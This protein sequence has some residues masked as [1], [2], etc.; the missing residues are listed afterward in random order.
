MD[1]VVFDAQP[2][3]AFVF[4]EPAADQVESW[5]RRCAR[6]GC[7]VIASVNWCEVLYV[8]A[9]R[10]DEHAAARAVYLLEDSGISVIDVGRDIATRA[11]DLKA[12]HALGLGDA[13]AAA[14]AMATGSP[15]LTGDTDFL[16]LADHGLAIEWV[17][18]PRG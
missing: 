12:R 2:L 7:G 17:G 1:T 11:A 10:L 13:F 9:R 5:M 16:P 8:I 14:L 18:E 4:D 3:V 6:T 15:L